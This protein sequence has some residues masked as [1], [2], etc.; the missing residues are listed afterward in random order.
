MELKHIIS[1][2]CLFG[3]LNAATIRY[4]NSIS[5][6]TVR[7]TLK[8]LCVNS[9]DDI[10]QEIP[11]KFSDLIHG[12]RGLEPASVQKLWSQVKSRDLCPETA[13]LEDYFR[14]ALV[15]V[16][17]EGSLKQLVSLINK[18][19]ISLTKANYG[20]T[21]LAFVKEPTKEAIKQLIPL[22]EKDD[23]LRQGLLGGSAFVQNYCRNKGDACGDVKEIREVIDVILRHLKSTEQDKVIV[24]L[25]AIRNIDVQMS[26]EQVEKVMEI[27]NDKSRLAGVRVAG[28]QALYASSSLKKVVQRALEILQ[29]K[30]NDSEIRINAYKLLMNGKPDV[31]VVN[32]V[33]KVLDIE[34]SKQVGSYIVSHLKNL[35]ETSDPRKR[36]ISSLLEKIELPVNK[37]PSDWRKFSR[38]FEVSNIYSSYDIGSVVEGDLIYNQDSFLPTAGEL[39]VALPIFGTQMNLFGLG[40]RQV[41]FQKIL[42]KLSAP[43][44]LLSNKNYPEIISE[45]I[46]YI[47]EQTNE[48]NRIRRAAAYSESRLGLLHERVNYG[49][50]D[51]DGSFYINFDGKTIFYM[52]SGDFNS[53]NIDSLRE[54]LLA[55]LRKADQMIRKTDQ[56]RAFSLMFLDINRTIQLQRGS[57][58]DIDVNGTIVA[59]FKNME[60]GVFPSF[61]VEVSAKVGPDT[62]NNRPGLKWSNNIFSAPSMKTVI[63]YKNDFPSK[64]TFSMPKEVMTLFSYKSRVWSIDMN[65]RESE[66]VSRQERTMEKCVDGHKVMGTK[67]CVKGSVPT[68]FF[69]GETHVLPLNGPVNFEVKVEKTDK[70]MSGWEWSVN[71]P[72]SSAKQ[73]WSIGFNTPGSSVNR[74]NKME[75][76]VITPRDGQ[77]IRLNIVSPLKSFEVKSSYR[78]NNNEANVKAEFNSVKS[79]KYLVEAGFK[80]EVSKRKTVFT[81][82]FIVEIPREK[83]MKLDGTITIDNPNNQKPKIYIDMYTGSSPADKSLYLKGDITRDGPFSVNSFKLSTNMEGDLKFTNFKLFCVTERNENKFI[84][85]LNLDYQPRG[86]MKHTIKIVSKMNDQKTALRKINSFLE[87]KM[88][89]FPEFNFQVDHM[90]SIKGR[91]FLENEVTLKWYDGQRSVHILETNQISESNFEHK[92]LFEMKPWGYSYLLNLN[93]EMKSGKSFKYGANLEN[94]IVMKSRTFHYTVDYLLDGKIFSESNPEFRIQSSYTNKINNK[95]VKGNFEYKHIQKKPLQLSMEAA[96]EYP[97]RKISYTDKLEEIKPNEF[98]GNTIL[99]WS[100]SKQ[101]VLDYVYRMKTG[102][103]QY[104]ID[105]NLKTPSMTIKHNGLLKMARSNLVIKSSHYYD[106]NQIY[107]TDM[108]LS[109]DDK[110]LISMSA[111]GIETRIEGNPWSKVKTGDINIKSSK[112]EHSSNMIIDPT[113][114]LEVNSKTNYNAKPV[115]VFTSV[116]RPAE[117][118]LITLSASD[119][120]TKMELNRN[121][122]NVVN[123]DMSTRK[124]NHNTKL[125]YQPESINVISKTKRNNEKLFDLTGEWNNKRSSILNL[126]GNTWTAYAEADPSAKMYKVKIEDTSSG[127]KHNSEVRKESTN[128]LASSSTMMNNRNYYDMKSTISP[129]G[130]SSLSIEA[131]QI[132]YSF[133]GKVDPRRS[134]RATLKMATAEHKVII[135]K[136]RNTVNVEVGSTEKGRSIAKANGKFS[137]N[138]PSNLNVVSNTYGNLKFDLV[139]RKEAK[140]EVNDKVNNVFHSTKVTRNPESMAVVSQTEKSGNKWLLDANWKNADSWINVEAPTYEA[141]VN[142]RPEGEARIGKV[143]INSKRSSYSHKT[144][145]KLEA[146]KVTLTT[147]LR[148]RR[149]DEHKG[150]VVVSISQPSSFNYQG[151]ETR[152]TGYINPFGKAKS[153]DFD[154]DGRRVKLGHSSSLNMEENKYTLAS[155]TNWNKENMYTLNS[156]INLNGKS[157]VDL[158]TKIGSGSVEYQRNRLAVLKLRNPNFNH[159][160][161]LSKSRSEIR[162]DSETKRNGQSLALVNGKYSEAE[163]SVDVQVPQGK[164]NVKYLANNEVNWSVEG[165]NLEH[166]T[167]IRKNRSVYV[168][169]NTKYNNKQI[170]K[171]DAELNRDV[172]KVDIVSPKVKVGTEFERSKR[173]LINV[174]GQ[175]LKHFTQII[176]D[177][178]EINVNSKTDYQRNN[179]YDLKSKISKRSI[180]NIDVS[181]DKFESS[182]KIDVLKQVKSVKFS[183]KSKESTRSHK[184]EVVYQPR[185]LTVDSLTRDSDSNEYKWNSVMDSEVS[186]IKYNDRKNDINVKVQPFNYPKLVDV[187]VKTPKVSMVHNTIL[188]RDSNK[189]VLKTKTNFNGRNYDLETNINKVNPS[190]N[191][192][193][194]YA[195]GKIEA[196]LAENEKVINI[197]M[198]SKVRNERRILGSIKT[199]LAERKY[200]VDSK[201]Q[202]DANNDENKVVFFS[203]SHEITGKSWGKKNYLTSVKTG[204]GNKVE[205][206]ADTSFSNDIIHG[207]HSI[208]IETKCPSNVNKITFVHEIVSSD[209]NTRFERKLNGEQM[210]LVD[211]RINANG[212]SKIDVNVRGYTGSVQFKNG[213]SGKVNLNLGKYNHESSFDYDAEKVVV[214]SNTMRNKRSIVD[215]DIT[216][217]IM[218]RVVP[219]EAKVNV[220]ERK[221]L[222]KVSPKELLINIDSDEIKLVHKTNINSANRVYTIRSNTILNNNNLID[223]NGEYSREKSTIKVV[224]PKIVFNGEYLRGSKVV[225]TINYDNNRLIHETKLVKS[226]R[227]LNIES[228]ANKNGEIIYTLNSAVNP[229]SV[230]TINF[231]CPCGKLNVEGSRRNLK[232]NYANKRNTFTHNTEL[233]LESEKFTFDTKTNLPSYYV[234]VDGLLHKSA[235]SKFNFAD[236]WNKVNAIVKP[237]GSSKA[238][239]LVVSGKLNL[240]HESS[241]DIDGKRYLIASVTDVN[242]NRIY[243]IKSD[244]SASKQNVNVESKYL[245]GKFNTL[246]NSEEQKVNFDLRVRVPAEKRIIGSI[247]TRTGSIKS[248]K[249]NLQVDDKKFNVAA[250]YEKSGSWSNTQMKTTFNANYNDKYSYDMSSEMSSDL[251]NGPHR[252]TIKTMCP[253]GQ[254]ETKFNH[255]IKSGSVICHLNVKRN[256]ADIILVDSS[257]ST[258]TTSRITFKTVNTNGVVVYEP[259]KSAEIIFNSPTYKHSTQV[260]KENSDLII[261]SETTKNNRNI[262][263]INSRLSSR[264]VSNGEIIVPQ[265]TGKFTVNP[266]KQLKVNINGKNLIHE[267]LIKKDRSLTVNS[268][269]RLNN[270]VIANVE[271]DFQSGKSLLKVETPKARFNGEYVKGEKASVDVHI[272]DLKVYIE[273]GLRYLTNY[274]KNKCNSRSHCHKLA[275]TFERSGV[276]GVKTEVMQI[277]KQYQDSTLQAATS[278]WEKLSTVYEEKMGKIMSKITCKWNKMIEPIKDHRYTRAVYDVV[279]SLAAYMGDVNRRIKDLH[280]STSDYIL[281]IPAVN[282][283]VHALIEAAD[284][285]ADEVD[286][287]TNTNNWNTPSSFLKYNVA[288]DKVQVSVDLKNKP[289][290]KRPVPE[291]FIKTHNL[292]KENIN[293]LYSQIN[294]VKA[295]VNSDWLPPFKTQAMIVGGQHF[296]TFDKTF[297]DFA[298]NDCTFLLA[299][300]FENGNF[301]VMAKY[302]KPDNS[303]KIRKS[304]LI[305]VNNQLIEINPEHST[306]KLNESPAELPLKLKGVTVLRTSSAIVVDYKRGLTL[307]C[308]L[309]HD[310]CTLSMSGWYY[311]KTQ[312]LFGSYDY[313]RFNDMRTPTGD[314]AGSPASFASSWSTKESCR[315]ENVARSQEVSRNTAGHQLC[316]NLFKSADSPLSSGF[317]VIN[318]EAYFNLCLRHVAS[319]S[320]YATAEK[321]TC[322]IAASYKKMLENEGLLINVPSRC[323]TCEN[324]LEY[325]SK[326]MLTT[327]GGAKKVDVVFVIEEHECNRHLIKDIHTLAKNI[328]REMRSSDVRFGVTGFAG[329]NDIKGIHYH[330]AR[331]NLFFR[332]SDVVL[333][334]QRMN[335]R[336]RNSADDVDIYEA[337]V[338]GSQYPFRPEASKNIILMTCTPCKEEIMRH[339]YSTIQQLLLS[340]GITMHIL[341]DR[342]IDIINPK[343]RGVFAVDAKSAFRGKD[344]SQKK[345]VGQPEMRSQVKP[346][347]DVCV[348]LAQESAGTF[349]STSNLSGAES[350]QWRTILAMKVADSSVPPTCVECYC[351]ADKTGFS[352]KST[353]KPCK[354]RS[355]VTHFWN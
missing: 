84:T 16:G 312:G 14:D 183:V 33:L 259:R 90:F 195:S 6:D 245:T 164:A 263:K 99:S 118:S 113:S 200:S 270:K 139:P 63:E 3:L 346:P 307:E 268:N 348:A 289:V 206:K 123:F 122:G 217:P 192:V 255:E 136:E 159:E 227:N 211:S 314:F 86:L 334:T 31:Y 249:S 149:G 131:P 11:E 317:S 251:V 175:R 88:S 180:S 29:D 20:L 100:P 332:S 257:L 187:S 322:T 18:K 275:R 124:I 220:Q 328:E 204:Y 44:G 4:S 125:N 58:I 13:K 254:Y 266:G 24:A 160:S 202:W 248:V 229:Q 198:I 267:T 39:D 191:A 342:S 280:E 288:D 221:G 281:S 129:A 287:L 10:T 264:S 38:H 55:G 327:S 353:C 72:T 111:A 212:L 301:T 265:G 216:V 285:A 298:A 168:N 292:I 48:I 163:S 258:K 320:R 54:V 252:V 300:D 309:E 42:E 74:E 293:S 26:G 233:N 278:F 85:D 335:L 127:L 73:I 325:G 308:Q 103:N 141:K 173:F 119:L 190:I 151:K 104:E 76:E 21:M 101:A 306:V 171:V 146:D 284:D 69:N 199:N 67:L 279:K 189:I 22:L 324:N 344:I 181:S 286:A 230:S 354:A 89:Q 247:E 242:G 52:E 201:L 8:D 162:F 331:S 246:V 15:M 155:K 40:G 59:S 321:A 177:N 323:F 66:I 231:E 35:K 128:W 93:G 78:L 172:V 256:S 290:L 178:Q 49:S 232:V 105:I 28:L 238:I 236:K 140:L 215:A 184:T 176:G 144:E 83:P 311:G 165:S 142:Y 145:G 272:E 239:N 244:L 138:E 260:N 326:S 302:D 71:I 214:K 235:E 57:P 336:P 273:Q 81:P 158:K 203:G 297:Y 329:S 310:I 234:N 17:T 188:N 313:E 46:N 208:N 9:I 262:L 226:G 95:S 68:P 134:A 98:K 34:E 352:P 135:D 274:L 240:K 315:V 1:F 25:K 269:T 91:E 157:N 253:K 65:N 92:V 330:T 37:F 167:S 337:I 61:A 271:G 53:V 7:S 120:K 106:D 170:L 62:K 41:N 341:N 152:V 43:N 340:E 50:S 108:N 56:D 5:E 218:V 343:A 193:T 114:S 207:K 333:A 276:E 291:S 51:F 27:V 147:Q 185:K 75:I 318:P 130:Y 154:F 169:S 94:K 2:F 150:D 338:F 182:I 222:L 116:I 197:D 219:L 277:V 228:S 132:D 241:L 213:E 350:K 133:N 304:I 115:Y 112:L 186:T 12:L 296:L 351:L 45:I 64:V 174:D 345:L 209:V 355:P 77:E 30:T 294:L 137:L 243:S 110:S 143:E 179:V 117:K 223:L 205:L 166:S 87:V 148:T 196:T 261:K 23:V 305:N 283:L 121:N 80:R 250:T 303:G 225:Y 161:T 107:T 102:K 347:K 349:F 60:N 79:G 319:T 156:E 316:E 224:S 299:R 126:D 19:E 36:E 153:A 97:G 82:K 282:D 47:K 295:S 339:D 237:F 96:L 194:P 32:K 109:A 70:R 210:T